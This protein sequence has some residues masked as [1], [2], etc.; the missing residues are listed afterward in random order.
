MSRRQSRR[1]QPSEFTKDGFYN[2]FFKMLGYFSG[3]IVGR[4]E[5]CIWASYG[6]TL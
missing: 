5:G 6:Q 3:D 4:L 1:K 2:D